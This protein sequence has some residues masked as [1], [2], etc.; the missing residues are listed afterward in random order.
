MS[1]PF[2]KTKVVCSCVFFVFLVTSLLGQIFFS[3]PITHHHLNS[4]LSLWHKSHFIGNSVFFSTNA[5]VCS[6]FLFFSIGS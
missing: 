2:Q 4:G 5:V 3:N 1:G 6:A